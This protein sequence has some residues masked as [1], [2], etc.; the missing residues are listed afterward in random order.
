M[1]FLKVNREQKKIKIRKHG[2]STLNYPI[3]SFKIW[4][5][6]TKG[7]NIPVVEFNDGVKNLQLVKN[8]YPINIGSIPAN[9]Y[10]LQANYADSSGVHNGGLLRLINDTWYNAPFKNSVTGNIEYKLRTAPQLFTSN[11]LVNHNNVKLGEVNESAWIEGY[12][13]NEEYEINGLKATE[14]TWGELK[15]ELT[16]NAANTSFQYKLRNA[17]DSRPVV[18][19]YTDTSKPSTAST[20]KFLGQFVLMDDKKSDHLYGQR[21][22]YLWGEGKDPFCMT[23]EGALTEVVNKKGNKK[24]GY[25]ISDNCVWDNKNVLRIECVL[26]NTPLTSFMNFNVPNDIVLDE[27]GN[28]SSEQEFDNTNS[29][30]AIK[31]QTDPS[32][33][34]F[35]YDDNGNKIPLNYYWEDYF[36]MIFPDEDDIAEDDANKGKT[37]FDSDSKFVKKAQP[38]LDFLEWICGIGQ[39]NVDNNGKQIV[40]GNVSQNALN[41]FIAEAHDHLDLYKLA[42]YYIFY[43]RFGL[44]DSVERNAQYKTYDGQHWF[45]EPWDMDIALGNKNTGGLA[46]DPPM[47]RTTFLD[48]SKGLYA[49]S[50]RS[51]S[52]SNVLWDCLESWSVWRDEIVPETAQALY[53]GGLTYEK[54]TE[55]FDENFANKW[56]EIIYNES[57][58]YKY[59]EKAQESTWLAWL[60]GSRTSHRHWWI[61]TSMNYYD[62]KWTCGQFNSS[63]IYLAVDKPQ[64]SPASIKIVPTTESY[65]KLTQMDTKL[66]RGL[67]KATKQEPAIWIADNW[68]FSAKDPAHIFGALFMEKIDLGNFGQGIQVLS[69]QNAVD[70]ELGAT[71]RELSIGA[72]LPQNIESVTS[73][74]G[75]VNTI[76]PNITNSASTTS[77]D[78]DES[79]DALENIITYNITGQLGLSSADVITS[80]RNKL[81]NI[82]AIGSGFTTLTS[83][84]VGNK[85]KDLYLPGQTIAIDV[86]NV[87]QPSVPGV[88]SIN[89]TNTSWENISF[90]S[91]TYHKSTT[92]SVRYEDEE[93]HPILDDEGNEI[94]IEQPTVASFTKM[95]RI[96]KEFNSVTFKGSTATN[97]CSLKFI[98]DWFD[99]IE[100]YVSQDNPGLTGD[101][102]ENK[103]LEYISKNCKAT[104]NN[105]RWNYGISKILPNGDLNPEYTVITYKDVIRLGYLNGAPN[106]EGHG[107]NYTYNNLI[108][109]IKIEGDRMTP[110][111][112]T[113]LINLFGENVFSINA[114]NS[115][116]VIDQESTYAQISVSGDIRLENNNIVSDEGSVIK[117]KCTSF[118][119]SAENLSISTE[120]Q[121]NLVLD[122]IPLTPVANISFFSALLTAKTISAFFNTFLIEGLMNDCFLYISNMSEP[123]AVTYVLILCLEPT[124]QAT[125]PAG[126]R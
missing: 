92:Q 125:A 76:K 109:Y 120:F 63:R 103:V 47:D 90:W 11:Q 107:V 3:A 66:S 42:A 25:D 94:Y 26:I 52:T 28:T 112:M 86:N 7:E 59:V 97:A 105:I 67:Q 102:L 68:S 15:A 119:L 69:F 95:E 37:K 122:S 79:I 61:S 82:Y 51:I 62:S 84:Q 20:K 10:V 116:L 39:L 106:D 30:A 19:F 71:I 81:K 89:V 43:I 72:E 74:D 35:V 8:R 93:G 126:N 6:Q 78:N 29:A 75:W 108:G 4:L 91:T 31:Y 87:A 77:L 36:E 48:S 2:Q 21:S 123:C 85:Y 70:P 22:I 115:N 14:H 27:D 118:L 17:P 38:W 58:L 53:E 110:S 64:G 124:S 1:L 80:N 56:S 5:N 111:Q 104:I 50:G 16:G 24:N 12:G 114:I 101:T 45:L 46:F 98:L 33:G 18:V 60:Q 32:T 99:S 23:A 96:P 113:R 49:Y 83:S 100:Y 73:F 40:N 34:N 65:F 54:I 44:V 13:N 88:T 41:K 57:G 117:L 121:Y 9:K 55:M